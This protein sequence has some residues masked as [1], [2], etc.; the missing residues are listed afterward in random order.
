[1]IVGSGDF[2][3]ELVEGWAKVPEYF[4]LDDPVN[5]A[6][7]SRDRVYVGSR[8]NHPVLIFDRDGNFVSCWGEGHFVD[9]HGL[10]IDSHDFVYVVDRLTHTVEKCTPGG[11]CLMTLG[12]RYRPSIS[13]AR[14]PFN[15][16]T[17]VTVSPSGDIFVSD[18]YANFLVHK[19]S[20]E[21]KLIKTW[22]GSGTGPGQFILPHR[23]DVDSHGIVYVCDRNG[24]R[25]QMF[26]AEGEF[27]DM[28]TDFKWPQDLWI[29]RKNDIVYVSEYPDDPRPHQPKISIR[30]LKGKI[31]AAWG[32]GENEENPVLANSH[33]ICVDSHGDIYVADIVRIKRIQ[34]F[35]KIS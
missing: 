9:P 11:E 1:M 13:Y 7:D 31:L 20:S 3:Y 24:D 12:T 14:K 27:V 15:L 8:G 2:K 25:I 21:G 19:F 23:I 28:W 32:P 16:P 6:I 26:T 35:I 4:I 29:D 34:K 10:Y 18:G 30:D 5:I 22:G 33:S 17:G